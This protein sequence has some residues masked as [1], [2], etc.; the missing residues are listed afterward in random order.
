[1]LPIIPSIAK[2]PCFKSFDIVITKNGTIAVVY[3][4]THPPGRVIAYPKYVATS[5]RTSWCR[6]KNLCFSRL[7]PYAPHSFL[8]V[9]D[10]EYIYDNFYQTT[11]PTVSLFV[12]SEIRRSQQ[13]FAKLLRSP[14]GD[15]LTE[16]MFSFLDKLR[17]NIRLPSTIIGITGSILLGMQNEDVSDIDIVIH[18]PFYMRKTLEVIRENRLFTP[19][20][21]NVGHLNIISNCSKRYVNATIE[22]WRR[23]IFRN[24]VISLLCAPTEC[25]PYMRHY[26]TNLA[27]IDAIVEVR[28]L[29][30]TFLP[31][32]AS[33]FGII[34]EVKHLLMLNRGM[35]KARLLKSISGSQVVLEVYNNIVSSLLYEGGCFRVTGLLSLKDNS[36][37]VV[38]LGVKEVVGIETRVG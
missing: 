30:E 13:G 27:V 3:G 21:L 2:I 11:L 31:T 34:R 36:V 19:L 7:P 29:Q 14:P 15:S 38:K 10:I 12:V 33:G 4:N 35:D 20:R 5:K 25:I 24:R 26:Y 22:Y 16:A 18:D 1:M 32:P 8:K 28:E 6:S 23:G 17:E 9:E 37:Q